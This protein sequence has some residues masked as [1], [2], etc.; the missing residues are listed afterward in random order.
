V[1]KTIKFL[2]DEHVD[3][4][5]A[6]GLRRR[7]VDAL[8]VQE[9]ERAGASDD[10]HLLFADRQGRVMFTQDADYLRFHASGFR[11]RGIVFGRKVIAWGEY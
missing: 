3:V 2:L 9:A 10:A 7:G 11:H 8:T 4:A 5:I 1:A 6:I